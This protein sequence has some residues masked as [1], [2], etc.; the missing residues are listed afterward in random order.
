MCKLSG[1]QGKVNY[2]ASYVYNHEQLTCALLLNAYVPL[3]QIIYH[4]RAVRA[5]K[6]C[7]A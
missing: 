6:S 3:Q 5:C 1:C 2:F 4:W 7:I